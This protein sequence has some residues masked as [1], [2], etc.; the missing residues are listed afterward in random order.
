MMQASQRDFDDAESRSMTTHTHADLEADPSWIT[1]DEWP[2]LDEE[3]AKLGLNEYGR[4]EGLSFMSEEEQA[5]FEEV[6]TEYKES[7][8]EL[9][10][11][12]DG[13]T[14]ASCM[15]LSQQIVGWLN[16]RAHPDRMTLMTRNV[17]PDIFFA[18]FTKEQPTMPVSATSMEAAVQHFTQIQRVLEG[19]AG[20]KIR[21]LKQDFELPDD[22]MERLENARASVGYPNQLDGPQFLT[23][24]ALVRL[25]TLCK[26]EKEGPPE[27]IISGESA[28]GSG[29]NSP[30][31]S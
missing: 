20:R 15:A 3:W 27:D 6:R 4:G 28:D 12:P 31:V 5:V 24:L 17:I 18:Y 8:M 7:V 13:S 25:N 26:A 9:A 14:A 30:N 11:H 23:F 10:C 22:W 29:L 21:D 1:P 16:D 2:R 19:D